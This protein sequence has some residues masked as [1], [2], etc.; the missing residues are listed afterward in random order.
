MCHLS[1]AG[2]FSSA[3]ALR[4]PRPVHLSP[5]QSRY[6]VDLDFFLPSAI[7][8]A[9]DC[10]TFLPTRLGEASSPGTGWAGLHDCS[11]RAQSLHFSQRGPCQSFQ[12]LKG[13]VPSLPP[14]LHGFWLA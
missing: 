7:S 10:Q 14:L 12:Y 5:C 13:K 1:L 11:L 9:R 6:P 2:S 8:G 3:R 4:P